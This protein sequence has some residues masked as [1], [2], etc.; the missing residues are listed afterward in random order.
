MGDKIRRIRCGTKKCTGFTDTNV[1]TTPKSKEGNWQ[2]HCGVCG[3][4][5]LLSESG[6]MKA[7]SRQEFD[8]QQLSMS[9]RSPFPVTRSPTGGV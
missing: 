6:M 9:L 3:F 8:L 7:T 5:N 1:A 4:W 2:F